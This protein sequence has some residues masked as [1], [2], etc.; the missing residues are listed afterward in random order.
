MNMCKNGQS[1]K[2]PAWLD[3]KEK[4]IQIP[5]SARKRVLVFKKASELMETRSSITEIKKQQI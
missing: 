1:E 4:K 2:Q 3:P 5:K